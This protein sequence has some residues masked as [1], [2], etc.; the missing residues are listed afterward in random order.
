MIQGKRILIVDDSEAERMLISTYLQDQGVQIYQALDGIDGIHKARLLVPDLILMDLDLPRCDGLAACKMLQLEPATKHVPVIFLSAY[1]DPEQRVQGLLAGAVD[2]IGKPFHFDE[3]KLRMAVHLDRSEATPIIAESDESQHQGL[4]QP[5]AEQTS[6]LHEIL[7]HSARIHLLKSLA[8]P[9]SIRQLA[10]EV[11]TSSKRLTQAFKHCAGLTVK[12]YL[13]EQRMK[14]ARKLLTQSSIPIRE[15]ALA[16]GFT[17][18]ANFSTA[19]KARF[20]ITPS[21]FRRQDDSC[22]SAG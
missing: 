7:F 6:H 18:S 19:F 20:A 12:E 16:I 4:S 13:R 9:P 14:E 10:K 3:V 17:S 5:S 15:V 8:D 21:R 22:A 1:S 2:F 11:G